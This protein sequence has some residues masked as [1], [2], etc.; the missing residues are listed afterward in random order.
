MFDY[1]IRYLKRDGSTSL[2]YRPPICMG[3]REALQAVMPAGDRETG[4]FARVEVWR[5][6]ERIEVIALEHAA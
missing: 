3:D 2:V 4:D 1:E 5:G 6:L